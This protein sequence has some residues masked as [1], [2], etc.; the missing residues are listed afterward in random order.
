MDQREFTKCQ[1][2]TN[3]NLRT[4]SQLHAR[5]ST[6]PLGWVNW[7]WP[8]LGLEPG[9]RVLEVGCGDGALWRGRM[10]VLPAGCFLVLSDLS[11]GMVRSAAQVLSGSSAGWAIADA[12]H[13]PFEGAYFD[14]V[15]ANHMLYHVSDRAATLGEIARVLRPG[16]RL[17][18]STVGTGHMR[19]MHGW[20]QQ[21]CGGTITPEELHLPAFTLQSG[22]AELAQ[23][24]VSVSRHDYP[25]DLR[26]PEIA[27]L[28][29]YMHS[30]WSEH[31]GPE[32]TRL[33][34]A[35]LQ[36]ELERHGEILVHKES[37]L[38]VAHK[39]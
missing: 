23:W 37:G 39:C 30:I 3:A 27:P 21:A 9:M 29:D 16:G 26:V 28:L 17:C 15:I 7:M 12:E 8:L 13:L 5:Y 34:K 25:D 33:L 36:D 10:D 32:Q 22:E 18:A 38:F 24:F 2:E 14:F 20:L 11:A 35:T 4:R 1:Y 31:M 19:E 6:N